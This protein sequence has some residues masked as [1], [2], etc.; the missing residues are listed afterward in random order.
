MRIFKTE[1]PAFQFFCKFIGKIIT[2]NQISVLGVILALPLVPWYFYGG[3]KEKG[4]CLF[5]FVFCYYL[6]RLDGAVARA[7][8]CV[9]DLGKII[10]PFCDKLRY[11]L[12]QL[13]FLYLWIIPAFQQTNL[14]AFY[15]LLALDVFSTLERGFKT[16]SAQGANLFGKAKTFF[17]A[18]N[19]FFLLLED[20]LSHAAQDKIEIPSLVPAAN[21]CLFLA[22]G[23]AIFSVG[24]RVFRKN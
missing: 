16:S 21:I 13:S 18:W 15:S 20:F 12:P 2:P 17:C 9:S 4:I 14:P 5:L 11:Y 23:L 10:D 6:D 22:L 8:N 7:C 24:K 1:T 3:V 19:F